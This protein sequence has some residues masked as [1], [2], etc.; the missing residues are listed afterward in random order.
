MVMVHLPTFTIKNRPNAG[1]YTIHGSYGLRAYQPIL[2]GKGTSIT[3][4]NLWSGV[5]LRGLTRRLS[6]PQITAVFVGS[7]LIQ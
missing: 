7:S 6:E 2:K 4:G 1:K 3:A 5:G